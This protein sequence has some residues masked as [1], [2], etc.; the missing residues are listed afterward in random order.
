MRDDLVF[1]QEKDSCGFNV[2]SVF[3]HYGS[4]LGT[5]YVDYLAETMPITFKQEEETSH[6]PISLDHLKQIVAFADGL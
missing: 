2:Y 5:V 3:F 1:Q 4:K 6:L